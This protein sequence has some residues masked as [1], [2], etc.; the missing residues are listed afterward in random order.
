MKWNTLPFIHNSANNSSYTNKDNV[1]KTNSICNKVL[2][3]VQSEE[4]EEEDPTTSNNNKKN[5][6]NRPVG[7]HLA[8]ACLSQLEIIWDIP[9]TEVPILKAAPQRVVI[10]NVIERMIQIVFMGT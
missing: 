1:I 8:G 9:P 3:L 7:W 2:A 4:E 10:W 6:T 5:N